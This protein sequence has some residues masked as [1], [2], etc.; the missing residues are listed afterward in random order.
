MKC[1]NI[2]FQETTKSY[3]DK[4]SLSTS[5][6]SSD[7]FI[8][9]ILTYSIWQFSEWNVSILI[10]TLI[11]QLITTRTRHVSHHRTQQ[12]WIM[13]KQYEVQ[14]SL[15]KVISTEEKEKQTDSIWDCELRKNKW[16]SILRN[17]FKKERKFRWS[18]TEV[19]CDLTFMWKHS[20]YL[21]VCTVSP[22]VLLQAL[23]CKYVMRLKVTSTA[24]NIYIF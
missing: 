11:Y 1:D 4:I 24:K 15:H 5:S 20:Q 16:P 19:K 23:Q 22:S 13:D 6:S 21:T 7:C 12:T 18:W 3:K 8:L 17:N 10:F 2:W 14:H 9:F